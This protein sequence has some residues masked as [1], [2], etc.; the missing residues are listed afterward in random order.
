METLDLVTNTRETLKNM[1]PMSAEL[2]QLVHGLNDGRDISMF[3]KW[4][5]GYASFNEIIPF[6][7]L[8]AK[9]D[10][11]DIDNFVYYK[12]AGIVFNTLNSADHSDFMSGLYTLH[13][14]ALGR[15]IVRTEDEHRGWLQRLYTAGWEGQDRYLFECLGMYQSSCSRDVYR[16]ESY[17]MNAEEYTQIRDM[18]QHVYDWKSV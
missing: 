15:E 10:E 13:H 9:M 16:H 11:G 18:R 1:F 7:Q 12:P 5:S 8:K 6:N 14:L 2:E 4:Y 3:D 17:E